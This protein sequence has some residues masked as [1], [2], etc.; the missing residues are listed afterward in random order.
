MPQYKCDSAGVWFKEV[1]EAYSTQDFHFYCS[2]SR[3]KGLAGLSKWH[4]Q[5]AH[6]FAEHDRD[7][8]AARNIRKRGLAW[9]EESP[10]AACR[11][12]A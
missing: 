5:C 10:T 7:I 9:L 6:C 8:K 11:P 4:W 3:P 2:R 1:D 12:S